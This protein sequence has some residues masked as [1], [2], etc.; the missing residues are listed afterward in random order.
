[1][2]KKVKTCCECKQ[3]KTIE[4]FYICNWG[5]NKGYYLGRCKPCA[6]IQRKAYSEEYYKIPW[7][8]VWRAVSKRVYNKKKSYYKYGIKN[9]LTIKDVK[10]LWL[11]DKAH[12]LK[13]P[14]ID[15]ID[16]YGDYTFEN[17]RFIELLENCRRPKRQPLK[18]GEAKDAE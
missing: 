8:R 14:S 15:R 9:K 4:N 10:T 11:R 13:Q 1:M 18:K 3:T 16:T 17:C 7:N 5:R 2:D 6:A 12:E